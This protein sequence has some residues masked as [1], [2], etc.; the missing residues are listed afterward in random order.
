M[1]GG[2]LIMQRRFR[3]VFQLGF[4]GDWVEIYQQMPA[5]ENQ[6]AFFL[7]FRKKWARRV[8]PLMSGITVGGVKAITGSLTQ[9]PGVQL[10]EALTRL[11]LA[12]GEK[13]RDPR[14]VPVP[15]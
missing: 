2:G 11:C 13:M 14:L 3:R 15:L 4:C 9:R 6:G 10:S 7:A 1:R 8:T 12:I 5:P